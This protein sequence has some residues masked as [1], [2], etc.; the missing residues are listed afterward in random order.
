[1]KYESEIQEIIERVIQDIDNSEG[2]IQKSKH[3]VMPLSLSGNMKDPK[4]VA[5]YL[6]ENIYSNRMDTN[7]ENYFCF[8]QN[9]VSEYS[10]IGEVIN[11]FYNPYAAS[12]DLSQGTAL[13]ENSLL[14]FFAERVGYDK[15]FGGQFV[16]GASVGNLSAMILARD[17]KL[18]ENEFHKGVVYLSDQAHSSLVK[19]A[20][21]IGVKKSHIRIVPSR[22]DYKMD[23]EA[24]ERFIMQD[25]EDG[26]IPFCV[27]GTLGTTNTGTID[28]LDELSHIAHKHNLW[29]HVDAA[30]GG[31]VLLSSYKVLGRGIEK[32]DSMTWD[33]HKWLF[34][35]YGCSMILCRDKKKMMKSFS[36]RPEY[37]RNVESDNEKINFWDLGIEMTRPARGMKLW[38]TLQVMGLDQVEMRI[39]RVF[40]FGDQLHQMIDKNQHIEIVSDASLGIIN[41]RYYNKF[42]AD[43]GLNKI[44][45]YISDRSIL[46]NETVFMTTT[47]KGI[48]T[49]RF[50]FKNPDTKL[51]T[52][53]DVISKVESWAQEYLQKEDSHI[54]AIS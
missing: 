3:D 19:A 37:L 30:Y 33:A 47:L 39:D 32:S 53:S 25:K 42:I 8:M 18:E 20:K 52:F 1:M 12:V 36:T 44:N 24:L 28:P 11:T 4:D 26:K 10:V 50:N 2:I 43:T 40:D 23:M 51:E 13:I 38:Y 41:F 22:E 35:T 9:D 7:N 6:I 54:T 48:T 5:R 17:D 14:D 31:S 29:F 27:V 45:Q 34:Q 16:S 21:I 49:L 46:E 15:A